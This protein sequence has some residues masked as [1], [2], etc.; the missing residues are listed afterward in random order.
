[1]SVL[2]RLTAP[3]QTEV[4]SATTPARPHSHKVCSMRLA[5]ASRQQ[6]HSP[7]TAVA[8]EVHTAK[9]STRIRRFPCHLLS[10]KLLIVRA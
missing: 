2:G 8:A 1:M 10:A 9:H 6:L 4:D 3:P 7:A 5:D